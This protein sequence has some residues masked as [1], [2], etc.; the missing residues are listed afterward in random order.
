MCEDK[1]RHGCLLNGIKVERGPILTGKEFHRE[2]MLH[3]QPSHG[4]LP[5]RRKNGT[6]DMKASCKVGKEVIYG[7]PTSKMTTTN[8]RWG[9]FGREFSH[10]KINIANYC[11]EHF[12]LFSR[13][14]FDGPVSQW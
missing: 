10:V 13:L 8:V 3:I 14:A 11:R 5:H 9:F 2:D 12:V 6:G 1:P 4:F 7:L